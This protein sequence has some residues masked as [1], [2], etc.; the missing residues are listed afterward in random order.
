MRLA[1]LGLFPLDKPFDL[2]WLLALMLLHLLRRKMASRTT[3]DHILV[4]SK[5]GVGV[6]RNQVAVERKVSLVSLPQG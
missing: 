1:F 6:G 3:H 4:G 2:L 5:P